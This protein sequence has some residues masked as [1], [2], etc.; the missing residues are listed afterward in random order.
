MQDSRLPTSCP[1][2]PDSEI[3]FRIRFRGPKGRPIFS[4][5][6]SVSSRR[7]SASIS[8]SRNVPSYCPSPRPRNQAPTSMGGPPTVQADD[9]PEETECPVHWAGMSEMGGQVIDD[10]FGPTGNGRS[11]KLNGRR[12]PSIDG[13]SR[14]MREYQVRI[15]ERLR[16]KFPGPTRQSRH[17]DPASLTSGLRW[18]VLQKSFCISCKTT[19]ATLSPK[20]PT[21]SVRPKTSEK[22]QYRKDA[23]PIRSPRRRSKAIRTRE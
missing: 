13:T 10:E 3:A 19:F 1:H 22:C 17:F 15:C 14:M 16:V 9:G 4:R 20:E 8:L 7:V 5:S 18:I 6:V 21:S 2:R 11:P 23:P 12:Q